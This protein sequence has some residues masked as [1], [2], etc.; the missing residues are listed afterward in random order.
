MITRNYINTHFVVLSRL[1]AATACCAVLLLLR[2]KLLNS[3]FLLFLVWN[4]IL[5]YVPFV[6]S[7]YLLHREKAS[8]LRT[9]ILGLVWLAFLPNAPY[10][11]TDL[12]HLQLSTPFSIEFILDAS[13]IVSFALT[14]IW[15]YVLSVQQMK[16]VFK[17]HA[18]AR[19]LNLFFYLLPFLV[20]FGVY[21]GRFLRFNSWDIL[22]NPLV[23]LQDILNLV[24]H[25]FQYKMGWFFIL[26]FAMLLLLMTKIF[27]GY[28]ASATPSP[29]QN[30]ADMKNVL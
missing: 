15:L 27:T 4:L 29:P 7:S 16:L 18:S 22:V 3:F 17:R 19:W 9:L 11:L 28:M 21:L 23:L 26:G 8:K 13:V 2:V 10:I 12:I 24:L 6:L 25:P 14:G 20:S 30:P 5:A 1:S